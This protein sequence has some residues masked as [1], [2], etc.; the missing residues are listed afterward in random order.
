MVS[1]MQDMSTQNISQTQ[2]QARSLPNLRCK[3]L[4]TALLLITIA[5]IQSHTVAN[6]G[7]ALLYGMLSIRSPH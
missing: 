7:P 4:L 5:T 1:N 3:R 2:R 6:R